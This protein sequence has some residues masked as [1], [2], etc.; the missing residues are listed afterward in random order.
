MSNNL[1]TTIVEPYDASFFFKVDKKRVLTTVRVNEKVGGNIDSAIQSFCA[2]E[3]IPPQTRLYLRAAAWALE[4]ECNERGPLLRNAFE[5]LP[6]S[7][8]KIDASS[9]KLWK[10]KALAPRVSTPQDAAFSNAYRLSVNDENLLT[11]MIYMEHM[12]S[13]AL[14]ELTKA[15]NSTDN[16]EYLLEYENEILQ[17]VDDQR[18]GY[19]EFVIAQATEIIENNSNN[20]DVNGDTSAAAETNRGTIIK[21]TNNTKD[22]SLRNVNKHLSY[23]NLYLPRRVWKE[24][25]IFLERFDEIDVLNHGINDLYLG[26]NAEKINNKRQRRQDNNSNGNNGNNNSIQICLGRQHKMTYDII[27]E[28]SKLNTLENILIFPI[29]N[30]EESLRLRKRH[31]VQLYSNNQLVQ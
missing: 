26:K 10:E 25:G 19:Q 23:K 14:Y 28:D 9:K 31:A 7:I 12:Y 24:R 11:N 21:N 20:T 17:T 4:N 8:E 22:A 1:A 5:L 18:K 13:K 16:E 3:G 15:K 29:H 2:S 27:L 30:D 6:E